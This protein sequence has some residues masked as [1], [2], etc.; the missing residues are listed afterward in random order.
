MPA[1]QQEAIAAL[2]ERSQREFVPLRRAFVQRRTAAK[3]GGPLAAFTKREGALDLYLL[4]HA[5]ASRAPWDVVLPA[6]V[7]VRLLGLD[8]RT[9]ASLTYVSRQWR[10]LSDQRL[11]R[12]ERAGR[13]RR[14]VLL[15]ED[16]SGEAYTHPG[17][18]VAGR[19]PEGDYFRLPYAYWHGGFHTRLDSAGKTVL[20]IALSLS[21]QD[22]FILPVEHGARWYGLSPE[23]IQAGLATLRALGLLSM[24]T[25][26]RSA[27]LTERGVTF[28]RRY[29]LRAPFRGLEDAP[30]V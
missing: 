24:R 7:W 19:P 14:V 10:W 15:R 5:L 13:H 23:R 20:L 26:R 30:V 11:V 28:E 4:L 29:S 18:G 25:V 12:L 9:E 27:P 21:L 17:L 1:E 16:G 3:G 22:E 8:E 2:L 6:R